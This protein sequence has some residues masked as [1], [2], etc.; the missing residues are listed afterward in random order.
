MGAGAHALRVEDE[1]FGF[2]FSPLRRDIF[3]VP[4]EA[5]A[6]GIPDP[7]DEFTRGVEGSRGG[8]DQSFLGHE[9]SVSGDRNPGVFSGADN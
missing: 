8:R 5:D 1:G 3:A 7:D 2:A 9:L 6:R 4:E